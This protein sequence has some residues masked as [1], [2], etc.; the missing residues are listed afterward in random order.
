M[1]KQERERLIASLTDDELIELRERAGAPP[2][3]EDPTRQFLHAVEVQ[4][5]RDWMTELSERLFPAP[6][7]PKRGN[8][9][10]HE[11]SDVRRPQLSD[12][13]RNVD[14]LRGILDPTHR[15]EL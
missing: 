3:H 5:N 9:V 2:A 15:P 10:A 12:R 4:R 8:H 11:G 6:P 13:D 1:N 7:Q 14:F